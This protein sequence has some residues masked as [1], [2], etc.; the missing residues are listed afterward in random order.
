MKNC[1]L[2]GFASLALVG[3]GQGNK[4]ANASNSAAPPANAAAPAAHSQN[5][6]APAAGG[7]TAAQVGAMI[8]RDGAA[9][10]VQSF[11]QGDANVPFD[12]VLDGIGSGNQEWLALVP[13]LAPGVDGGTATGLKI[14]IAEA[15]PRNAAAVLRL[16]SDGPAEES[17]AY[18]MIEPTAAETQAYFAAAIP[19]VEAIDDPA[20]QAAKTICLTKLREAQRVAPEQKFAP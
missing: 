13:K 17:C 18:P 15:L 9:K 8:D 10:T 6:A 19:A 2:V 16:G 3:C 11:D 20:L 14:A 5:A 4:S 7:L 12:Q 1:L